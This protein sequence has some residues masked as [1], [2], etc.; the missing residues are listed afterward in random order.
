MMKGIEGVA[1]EDKVVMK[2]RF[3]PVLALLAA[4]S[5]WVLPPT[6]TPSS[7]HHV[8]WKGRKRRRD[9]DTDTRLRFDSTGC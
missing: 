9:G 5:G 1:E 7:T 6:H 2:N 4:L 3:R 8:V